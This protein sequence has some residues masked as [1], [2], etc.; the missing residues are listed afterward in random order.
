MF[1]RL[2]AL[3]GVRVVASDLMDTRLKLSRSWGAWKA[4]RA[5]APDFADAIHRLTRGRGLD[6]AIIAVPSDAAVLQAM[7]LVRGAGQVLL[8]AHTRRRE[9]VRP[10]VP[11]GPKQP[12]LDLDLS[13]ICV[14]EKDLIGSYSSDFTLQQDVARLVF[15]R[16]LDV[17]R[18][19]THEFPLEKTAEAVDL[20]AHPHPNSLKIMVLP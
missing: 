2:L 17:R 4:L 5:D 20:A 10:A 6:A 11:G 12:C 18:L 16:K 14:D 1:T 7:Q 9:K 19:V 3:R 8:F 13:A 15:G